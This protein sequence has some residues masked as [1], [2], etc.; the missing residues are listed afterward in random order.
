MNNIIHLPQNEYK[1]MLVVPHEKVASAVVTRGQIRYS[2][3]TYKVYWHN[4]RLDK[5]YVTEAFI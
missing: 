5:C 4:I 1:E 2:A 3:V